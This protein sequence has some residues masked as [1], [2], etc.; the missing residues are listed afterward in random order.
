MALCSLSPRELHLCCW[1]SLP[2][3]LGKFLEGKISR[4]IQIVEFEFEGNIL[5]FSVSVLCNPFDSPGF[6]WGI[7]EG[8]SLLGLPG[9]ERNQNLYSNYWLGVSYSG[10]SHTTP[11][12]WSRIH[13]FIVKTQTLI[14]N[15][16]I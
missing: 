16:R 2:F 12:K 6:Y 14:Q 13:Y 1:L 7:I 9:K 5:L 15:H 4:F 3:P 11:Q 10:F 8:V